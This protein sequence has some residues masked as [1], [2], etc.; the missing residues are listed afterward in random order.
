MGLRHGRRPKWRVPAPRCLCS[1]LVSAKIEAAG[2]MN[3]E[4]DDS[5]GTVAANEV[6]AGAGATVRP[7][8]LDALRAL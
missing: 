8:R 4:R 2:M 3:G 7:G 6:F 1:T 5:R